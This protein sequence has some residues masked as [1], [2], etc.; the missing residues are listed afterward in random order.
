M[1]KL[2]LMALS[3]IIVMMCVSPTEVMGQSRR[4]A[5][6]ASSTSVH[7]NSPASG[8]SR[9]TATKN[10]AAASSRTTSNSSR[11]INNNSASRNNAAV[12]RSNDAVKHSNATRNDNIVPK[13][14]NNASR[15]VTN[16]SA[17]HDNV[18]PRSNGNAPKVS[19]NPAREN[20]NAPRVNNNPP[21]SNGNPAVAHNN[22]SRN[23][24][25]MRNEPP[26]RNDRMDPP[27]PMRRPEPRP[28]PGPRPPRGSHFRASVVGTLITIAKINALNNA[29]RR[30][31]NAAR[32]AGRYAVVVNRSYTP[33]TY[34]SI[35]ETVRDDIDYYYR[36]GVFYIIGADGDY[37]VIEPPIGALVES[38]PSDFERVVIDDEIFYKVDDT[39]YK[40]TIIEGVPYFEVVL[41]L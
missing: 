5:N 25:R 24:D 37:Y 17:R 6:P 33:R 38:I 20:S 14:N 39:L 4:S 40:V 41:N 12:T 26:R 28:A 27:R 18:A 36:D 7:Q 34:A 1:K 21:K 13:P 8:S 29:I 9:S 15:N 19:N 31:E 23:D 3:L 35:V 10:A 32:I 22:P 11:N 30:A 2:A 16:N